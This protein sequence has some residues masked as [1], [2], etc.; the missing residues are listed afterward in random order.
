MNAIDIE[1]AVIALT[2]DPSDYVI[3]MQKLTAKENEMSDSGRKGETFW[4]TDCPLDIFKAH[5]DSSKSFLYKP[6]DGV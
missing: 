4:N 2:G 3:E 1:K 5:P 6:D